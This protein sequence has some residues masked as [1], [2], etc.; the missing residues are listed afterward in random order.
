MIRINLLGDDTKIDYSSKLLVAGFGASLAACVVAFF[1]MHQAINSDVTDLTGQ[2]DV[3]E[4]NLSQLREKTKLV[5]D[6]E[7]KRDLLNSKIALIAKLKKSKI[8]PVRVMDDFNLAVPERIWIRQVTES[9]GKMEFHG[10]ALDN[11]DIALFMRN[12]D[13]SEYFSQI[14]LVE[15]RQMYYSK[16]TGKVAPTP[17]LKRLKRTTFGTESR[18]TIRKSGQSGVDPNSRKK[19]EVTS[20]SQR[21]KS[22]RRAV[23]DELNIKIKEFIVSAAVNYAGELKYSSVD[24]AREKLGIK[25]VKLR[26]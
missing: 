13:A 1:L 23:V 6:L 14:E 3:L 16:V 17:E 7:T 11:Q 10:R 12:L 4:R 21:D 18:V 24:D 8:G 9:E 26:K 25:K 2:V 20:D 22:G 5:K 19:S 15:S